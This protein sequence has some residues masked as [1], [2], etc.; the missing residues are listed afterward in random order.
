MLDLVFSFAI[1]IIIGSLS[2]L[3]PGLHINNLLPLISL[4]GIFHGESGLILISSMVASQLVFNFL[5]STFFGAA[6]DENNSLAALPSHKLLLSG[7]GMKSVVSLIYGSLLGFIFSLILIAILFGV[8]KQLY[9]YSRNLIAYI[10]I[11]VITYLILLERKL[12]KIFKSILI[13]LISGIFGIIVLNNLNFQ[14][15][16]KILPALTGL[17]GISSLITS[18]YTKTKIPKQDLDLKLNIKSKNIL[19]ASIVGSIA[20][21]IVGLLPAIGVAQGIILVSSFIKLNNPIE[22]LLAQGSVV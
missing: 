2:G 5:I 8:L 6:D 16:D 20:G 13:F 1:G 15:E 21:F 11:L 9:M 7:K 17:F 3:I 19:K 4:F 14:A 22:F 12:S 18:I 10:I